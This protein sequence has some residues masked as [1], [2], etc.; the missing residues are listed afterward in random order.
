MN[1]SKKQADWTYQDWMEKCPEELNAM[2]ETNPQKFVALVKDHYG[3]KVATKVQQEIEAEGKKPKEFKEEYP[4]QLL[5]MMDS[6]P[7]KF[8][9][10][11]KEHYPGVF[12]S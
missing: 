6:N 3:E 5:A 8:K 11:V 7:E 9:A 2:R 1:T 4:G 10:I 12:K